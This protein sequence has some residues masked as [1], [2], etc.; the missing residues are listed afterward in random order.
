MSNATIATV[1]QIIGY[2]D[3]AFD[4]AAPFAGL[5]ELTPLAD[6]LNALA[7][8]VAAAVQKTTP[9]VAAEI[10]AAD[11]AAKAAEVAAGLK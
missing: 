8:K 3:T 11:A 2:A 5:G 4:V 9:P 6:A 7:Q 1:L 10:A